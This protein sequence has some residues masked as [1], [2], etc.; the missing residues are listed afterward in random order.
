MKNL[1]NLLNSKKLV[2]IKGLTTELG[3][4][5]ERKELK[6]LSQCEDWL[7]GDH[8]NTIKIILENET[9]FFPF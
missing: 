3:Y 6:N 2:A 1:L 8:R 9:V 7:R 4:T 5:T